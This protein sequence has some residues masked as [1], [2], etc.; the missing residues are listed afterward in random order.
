MK[1]FIERK[2]MEFRSSPKEF[3]LKIKYVRPILD[4]AF[5][6][7]LMRKLHER[8]LRKSKGLAASATIRGHEPLYFSPAKRC[9]LTYLYA[10][11]TPTVKRLGKIKAMM[12]SYDLG[13]AETRSVRAYIEGL[14]L[15]ENEI[16]YEPE[17]FPDEYV[18]VIGQ[19]KANEDQTC[20]EK[21]NVLVDNLRLLSLAM[22]EN[23]GV[24]ILYQT[25][26]GD[27][28]LEL[29]SEIQEDRTRIIAS[30]SICC[31]PEKIRRAYTWDSILA[32]EYLL[33]S[34]PVTVLGNPFYS[35]CGLTDDRNPWVVPAHLS[36]TVEKLFTLTFLISC[37]LLCP[38]TKLP[39]D[40]KQ[41]LAFIWM[42][43]DDFFREEICNDRYVTPTESILRAYSSRVLK[44]SGER[45]QFEA[46]FLSETKKLF[47]NPFGKMLYDF[48]EKRTVSP[49]TV[50]GAVNALPV[51]IMRKCFLFAFHYLGKY[52][53]FD[54]LRDVL[55][56]Y[57]EYFERYQHLM[58]VN[59]M[60][61]YMDDYICYFKKLFGRT[62]PR[63]PY[64]DFS[65]SLTTARKQLLHRYLYA[66]IQ[67]FEY[68]RAETLLDASE[69]V[70]IG[71]LSALVRECNTS[72]QADPDGYKRAELGLKLAS[73]ILSILNSIYPDQM[74]LNRL[75]YWIITG[76][77]EAVLK[78]YLDI[79]QSEETLAVLPK[80]LT[81]LQELVGF[82][83]NNGNLE[84][85]WQINQIET[86]LPI[87][88][89]KNSLRILSLQGNVDGI[90]EILNDPSN[91]NIVDDLSV[92]LWQVQALR[93]QEKFAEA[94]ALLKTVPAS[95]LRSASREY[96]YHLA[97]YTA[98]LL[99]VLDEFSKYYRRVEQPSHPKGVVV[100]ASSSDAQG[101]LCLSLDAPLFLELKRQGYAV[102]SLS[103]GM[104]EQQK[105][106][107]EAIDQCHGLVPPL[108]DDGE[109]KLDWKIDLDNKIVEAEG[110]NFYQGFYERLS[111]ETRRYHVDFSIPPLK[112]LFNQLLLKADCFLRACLKI[113]AQSAE[114]QL[115]VYFVLSIANLAPYSVVRDFCA[116][117]GGEGLQLVYVYNGIDYYRD[118]SDLFTR[119]LTVANV[120]HYPLCRNPHLGVKEKF[121]PWYEK[122]GH[123]PEVS[124]GIEDELNHHRNKAVA[125][126]CSEIM[127]R[128]RAEKKAGKKII[129]CFS[130]LLVDL[131]L[132]YDGG[133]GGHK[134][135]VEWIHHTIR[136][137]EKSPNS[138]LLLKPHPGEVVPKVARRL[139]EFMT[140][141]LPADLPDNVILL[142]HQGP[143]TQEL[144]EVLDLGLLW[145]GT[146]G[147]ELT[148]LGV[149]VM[150]CSYWG[151]HDYLFDIL[152][153]E[154]EGR[155]EDFL[156]A[157]KFPPVSPELARRAAAAMYYRSS[158]EVSFP[159]RYFSISATND[160]IG[161]QRPNAERFKL[162]LQ[163]GDKMLER[164]VECFFDGQQETYPFIYRKRDWLDHSAD[165]IHIFAYGQSLS[166][167]STGIPALSTTQP[168]KNL[169]F[170]SGVLIRPGTNEDLRTQKQYIAS[171]FKPLVEEQPGDH[172]SG[173][174]PVSAA[175]NGLCDLIKSN[176]GDRAE[177]WVFIGSAPGRGGVSIK[178]LGPGG[179]Y[180]TG[181]LTQV[182]DAWALSGKM[183]KNYTVGAMLWA[184]GEND[185]DLLPEEYK[186]VFVNLKETFE[187]EVRAVTGQALPPLIVSYQT[188]SHRAFRRNFNYAAMAQWASALDNPDIIMATPVYFLPHD[189]DG[190]HLTNNS[191]VQFGKYY[192]RALY[193]TLFTDKPWQPL[194]PERIRWQER[195]IEI[196]F[197]VPVGHLVW[198]TS[199]V[200]LTPNYGFDLWR[201]QKSC[202]TKIIEDVSL[203][204]DQ[205]SVI[206][207]LVEKPQRGDFLTYG[208]GRPGDP[209]VS[210]PLEGP[211]GNLRDQSGDDDYYSDA[212]GV[213]RYMH[214]WGVMFENIFDPYGK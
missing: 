17:K 174:S 117:H 146:A 212:E 121:I 129:C 152:T 54:E 45:S 193:Q 162:Y 172:P 50:G 206:I 53:K 81:V 139:R 24:A 6:R 155:Y 71:L 72:R 119:T 32:F 84:P 28:T 211:R 170:Q 41:G 87:S 186:R 74:Q 183:D 165:H 82:L 130:R 169:T 29:V 65:D 36:V 184:Q 166:R 201:D 67:N 19:K 125:S 43:R 63:V 15:L 59:F 126:S 161:F 83:I 26:D 86:N 40:F 12:V 120:T 143:S 102:I 188:A 192:A 73:R 91:E 147:Y 23:P 173:E 113:K 131:I 163:K 88:Q 39:M 179:I 25:F 20:A 207:R 11:S 2:I 57:G 199:L 156:C 69:L 90:N 160:L 140:D 78:N 85:A 164:A 150:L 101:L 98:D 8:R 30:K 105:T 182:K 202:L 189:D 16:F 93:H 112:T 205:K 46:Y 110:I 141:I 133:P 158:E 21:K 137:I 61:E 4:S 92:K 99:E 42:L 144:A 89:T 178:D 109:I 153:P 167:G 123:D 49:E 106:G 168:Y 159:L 209:F 3:I 115:P 13:E 118:G 196:A 208:R 181:L 37:N 96:K 31:P 56:I 180:W 100:F 134:D 190:I 124:R 104:L 151:A 75:Y 191:Y 48:I 107:I 175:L 58:S 128:L 142:E 66:L 35:G 145:S 68:E 210:G 51:A 9:A 94:Y 135:I 80:R 127:T 200:A 149:P 171:A 95:S 176:R 77:T 214:N 27:S 10:T 103:R 197:H 116:K 204:S 203:G 187:T 22:K 18:L 70:D 52:G 148:M 108:S 64:C 177:D 62:I 138:I 38:V 7:P 97:T 194:W 213:V 132:P 5:F 44:D 60:T 154:S 185:P 34:V 33:F 79:M 122:H 198:D 76:N 157:G 14:R 195:I 1:K 114:A 111:V 55:E 136:I 47:L